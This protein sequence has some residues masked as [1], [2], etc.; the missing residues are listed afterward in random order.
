MGIKYLYSEIKKI[1][2]KKEYVVSKIHGKKEVWA[3]DGLSLAYTIHNLEPYVLGC[4]QNSETHLMKIINAC[5]S[6]NIRLVVFFDGL[7]STHKTKTLRKRKREKNNILEKWNNATT[8]TTTT[9]TTTLPPPPLPPLFVSW[10][11]HVLRRHNIEVVGCFG[12]ADNTLP[13][14]PG[15]DRILSNDS[16][17]VL[18][19]KGCG[20]LLINTMEIHDDQTITIKYVDKQMIQDKY[21]IDYEM[22]LLCCIHLGTDMI[23]LP[24]GRGG[25]IYNLKKAIQYV[26]RNKIPIS[27]RRDRVLKETMDNYKGVNA[28]LEFL[29]STHPWRHCFGS[30]RLS[31][32][33]EY[34]TY[35]TT[36][37]TIGRIVN[38]CRSPLKYYLTMADRECVLRDFRTHEVY[39]DKYQDDHN[40]VDTIK[41]ITRDIILDNYDFTESEIKLLHNHTLDEMGDAT[42]LQ[43]KTLLHKALLY[44]KIMVEVMNY[45]ELKRNRCLNIE[46]FDT[47]FDEFMFWEKMKTTC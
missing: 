29:T 4:F 23:T 32:L 42:T 12:E 2:V 31:N 25:G 1:A 7:S 18:N 17:L 46:S 20:L 27:Y 41:L 22:L 39:V 45:L 21:S 16:D 28:N 9:T 26:K 47:L 6:A 44:Q 11:T 5:S 13:F 30:Y 38:A 34:T 35:G 37:N 15:V 19:K 33:K 14:Y 8:T 10:F 43:H 40:D 36:N 24:Q 3:V